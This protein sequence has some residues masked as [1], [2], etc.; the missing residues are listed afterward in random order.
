MKIIKVVNFLD[1]LLLFISLLAKPSII[2][3]RISGK[4]RLRKIKMA[5]PINTGLL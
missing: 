1:K 3:V 4:K 2:G 5:S